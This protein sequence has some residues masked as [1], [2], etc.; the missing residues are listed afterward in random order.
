MEFVSDTAVNIESASGKS[1]TT[2][3]FNGSLLLIGDI[4]GMAAKIDSNGCFDTPK[5]LKFCKTAA[6]T[7]SAM[8]AM[9]MKQEQEKAA[10]IA[11]KIK[12]EK[13]LEVVPQ[14]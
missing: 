7:P 10:A 14:F 5:N 8:K 4:Q 1:R 2:Y 11:A 6:P 9:E 3:K 13:A 12:K